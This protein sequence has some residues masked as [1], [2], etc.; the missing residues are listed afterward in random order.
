MGAQRTLVQ[1][2][3]HGQVQ[4]G[5]GLSL[6]V[7]AAAAAAVARARSVVAVVSAAVMAVAL[8]VVLRFF[9]WVVMMRWSLLFVDTA[10]GAATAAVDPRL[11]SFLII[12]SNST[13]HC[14][15]MGDGRALV[16][17]LY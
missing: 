8:V 4:R 3:S 13:S 6:V 5:G 2:D 9:L 14:V 10:A 12:S 7:G 11:C 15:A 17:L 16:C 1:V